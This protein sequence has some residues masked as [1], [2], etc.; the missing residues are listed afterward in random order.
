M[1][2]SLVVAPV[3]PAGGFGKACWPRFLGGPPMISSLLVVSGW[4]LEVNMQRSQHGTLSQSEDGAAGIG[5]ATPKL[6][7]RNQEPWQ[8]VRT[9]ALSKIH[10]ACLSFLKDHQLVGGFG[11]VHTCEGTFVH[12]SMHTYQQPAQPASPAPR[13]TLRHHLSISED[14]I[15]SSEISFKQF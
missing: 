13:P 10:F 8:N 15:C 9:V 14:Q 3:N 12:A 2:G 4:F 11:G 7:V 5:P 1:A 6:Q